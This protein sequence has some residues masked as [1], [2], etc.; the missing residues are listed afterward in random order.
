MTKAVVR[1]RI[2][3]LSCI[4]VSLRERDSTRSKRKNSDDPISGSADSPFK[5]AGR[6]RLSAKASETSQLRRRG[7]HR[8]PASPQQWRRRWCRWRMRTNSSMPTL[9]SSCLRD[10]RIV[11]QITAPAVHLARKIE[12]AGVIAAD[13]DGL[14]KFTPSYGTRRSRT[15]RPQQRTSPLRVMPQF[16]TSPASILAHST[17]S[18]TVVP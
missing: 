13:R 18:G 15:S 12:A 9:R 4:A 1:G 11:V 16:M 14:K 5:F 7:G 2:R 6:L 3:R 10:L 17:P 8:R